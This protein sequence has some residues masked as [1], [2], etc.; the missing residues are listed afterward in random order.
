MIGTEVAALFLKRRIQLLMARDHQMWLY[1]GD[2]DSTRYN[3]AKF[4]D[5]E[6]MDEDR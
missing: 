3:Q 2:K 4:T 1:T 5:E 6:L